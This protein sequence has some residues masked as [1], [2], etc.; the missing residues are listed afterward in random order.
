M[1]TLLKQ[2]PDAPREFSNLNGDT[3]QKNTAKARRETEIK[4]VEPPPED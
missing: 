3:I 2:S 1:M 4:I